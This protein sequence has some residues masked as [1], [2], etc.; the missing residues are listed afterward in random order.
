MTSFTCTAPMLGGLPFPFQRKRSKRKLGIALLYAL[1]DCYGH[2]KNL[3]DRKTDMNTL[4]VS[5]KNIELMEQNVKNG[6]AA[7]VLREVIPA[8]RGQVEISV[9]FKQSG[10]SEFYYFN[11]FTAET[12]VRL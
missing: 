7:F 5:Q 1:R 8:T 4:G 10:Q 3:E 11:K 6:V 12:F 2:L 9:P